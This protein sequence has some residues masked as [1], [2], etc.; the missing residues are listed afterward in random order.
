L[1]SFIYRP[2]ELHFW[3]H[4]IYHISIIT[5]STVSLWKELAGSMTQHLAGPSIW[6]V[7]TVVFQHDTEDGGSTFTLKTIPTNAYSEFSFHKSASRRR[8]SLS[9]SSPA[10]RI[11]NRCI[12]TR[13]KSL[14]SSVAFSVVFR[15]SRGTGEEVNQTRGVRDF[16]IPP[17]PA[18]AVPISIGNNG[19][20]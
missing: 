4:L 3:F 20:Q 7:E 8:G 17:P 14:R 2:A 6:D 15:F 1:F 12:P 13:R 11:G 9:I 18:G 16:V 5:L 10:L 19:G